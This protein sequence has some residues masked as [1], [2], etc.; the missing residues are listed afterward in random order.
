MSR[1][2][3]DPEPYLSIPVRKLPALDIMEEITSPSFKLAQ[4]KTC[5]T[6]LRKTGY[7]EGYGLGGSKN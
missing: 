2:V 3:L 6:R 7:V 4:E 1:I 5:S